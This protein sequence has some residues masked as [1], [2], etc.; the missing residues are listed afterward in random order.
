MENTRTDATLTLSDGRTLGYAEYGDHTGTP[1]FMFHGNPGSRSAGLP[2]GVGA[3]R[4]AFGSS[5]RTD[6]DSVFRI[7]IATVAT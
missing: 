3:T 2:C 5:R 4:Q 6:Q 7:S 1:V